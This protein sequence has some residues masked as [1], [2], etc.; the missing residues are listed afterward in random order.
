V[1]ELE[2][3]PQNTGAAIP[4]AASV[5]EDSGLILAELKTIRDQLSH[6]LSEA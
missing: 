1:S 6:A 2:T 3:A 4:M 5:N